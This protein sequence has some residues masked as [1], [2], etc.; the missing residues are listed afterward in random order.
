MLKINQLAPS[1]TLLDQN[2][3]SHKLSDYK[4][5]WLLIYFYPKDDTPGCTTEACEIRDNWNG[6]KKLKTKVIGISKDSP[7]SHQ[8]FAQKYQLPF[9]LLADPETKVIQK[10]DAWQE[11]S[12]YGKKYMGIVR[13]SVLINPKGKIAKIYPKVKPKDHAE[14]VINDIKELS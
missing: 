12:M 7:E 11:K 6:F 3:K 10:Y 2:Q 4:G 9:T 1:F 8:K 13:S 5:E 14:E